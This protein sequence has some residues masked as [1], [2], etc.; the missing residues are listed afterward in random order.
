MSDYV[1]VVTHLEMGWDNVCGVYKTSES[2]YRHC[3]HDNPE[4]LT[5]EEMTAMVEDGDTS[6]VVSAKKLE[7]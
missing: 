5:L 7:E 6:Y 2:A 3:F 4:N 1:F